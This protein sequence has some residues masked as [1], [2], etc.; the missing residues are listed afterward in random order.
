MMIVN[1]IKRNTR[2]AVQ[3][4]SELSVEE[5]LTTKTRKQSKRFLKDLILEEDDGPYWEEF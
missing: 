4:I 3:K 1:L 2:N 5:V